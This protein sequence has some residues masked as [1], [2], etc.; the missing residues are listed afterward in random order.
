MEFINRNGNVEE[1]LLKNVRTTFADINH[2]R[3][4]WDHSDST[5]RVTSLSGCTLLA[6]CHFQN[7]RSINSTDLIWLMAVTG[8]SGNELVYAQTD[9]D[10]LDH[11]LTSS[12]VR[13]IFPHRV[14]GATHQ[15]DGSLTARKM[16]IALTLK[17]LMNADNPKVFSEKLS[18]LIRQMEHGDAHDS[19]A[20]KELRGMFPESI[21]ANSRL[22]AT[23]TA[24]AA[25]TAFASA[26]ASGSASPPAPAPTPMP[27]PAPAPLPASS[28]APASAP[29]PA[30]LPVPAPTQSSAPLP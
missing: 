27:T 30:Q 14:D 24:T 26:S 5:I 7:L 15:A 29:A 6:K 3:A 12:F 23:A 8:A 16:P 28:P 10:E 20:A 4:M 19:F 1:K 13:G 25:A 21:L 9:A 2:M 18:N 11:I 17:I 22:P